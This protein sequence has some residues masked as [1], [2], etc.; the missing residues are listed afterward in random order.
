MQNSVR[1]I[2]VALAATANAAAAVLSTVGA[3]DAH[4]VSAINPNPTAT[5]RQW[6]DGGTVT[7]SSS[8]TDLSL[9]L[10][11]T[12]GRDDVREIGVQFLP[13]SGSSGGS[14]VYVDNVTA[15]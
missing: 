8:G 15:Q 3:A 6:Y 12:G 13:A 14:S 11:G 2:A 5:T 10:G 9:N 4:P 7:V 1:T